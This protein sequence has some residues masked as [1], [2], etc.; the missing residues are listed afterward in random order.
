[1]TR[2]GRRRVECP[3][4]LDLHSRW[5]R[6]RRQWHRQRRSHKRLRFLT[7]TAD[8]AGGGPGNVMCGH[9]LGRG[10]SLSTR[11]VAICIVAAQVAALGMS[12]HNAFAMG[13]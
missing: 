10:D 4:A 5:H 1:M 13:I 2:H 11:G 9:I 12:S 6:R 8:G 3:K 7:G